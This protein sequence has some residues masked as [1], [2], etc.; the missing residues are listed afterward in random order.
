LMAHHLSK[1]SELLTYATA[2][3]FYPPRFADDFESVLGEE[4]IR[5]GVCRYPVVPLPRIVVRSCA[6]P[7]LKRTKLEPK[8]EA[9]EAFNDS[10]EQKGALEVPADVQMYS[11]EDFYDAPAD[12]EDSGM[13]LEDSLDCLP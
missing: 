11:D 5:C 7:R 10:S 2:D 3:F 6:C 1:T 9:L 12:A 13:M 4:V 8:C